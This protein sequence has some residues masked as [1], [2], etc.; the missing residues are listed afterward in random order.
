VTAP[1]FEPVIEAISLAGGELIHIVEE[2]RP[3]PAPA[4]K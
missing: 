2:E 3:G 1:R 4:S